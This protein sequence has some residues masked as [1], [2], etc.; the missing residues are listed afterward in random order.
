L[1]SGDLELNLEYFGVSE[2]TVQ[3]KRVDLSVAN[4]FKVV[5]ISGPAFSRD[6]IPLGKVVF[7]VPEDAVPATW[8]LEAHPEI[9]QKVAAPN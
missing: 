1:T 6:V 4:V 5:R 8:L 2:A 3:G 7:A 9:A